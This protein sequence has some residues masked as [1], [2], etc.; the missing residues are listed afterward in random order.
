MVFDAV[1]QNE[2]SLTR[3]M[4]VEYK[5]LNHFC[6]IITLPAGHPHAHI[7]TCTWLN[8]Q[9]LVILPTVRER[10][11]EMYSICPS[12]YPLY[13]NHSN[14]NDVTFATIFAG[15][16]YA[17][18]HCLHAIVCVCQIFLYNFPAKSEL[19]LFRCWGGVM[20]QPSQCIPVDI[21]F[22]FPDRSRSSTD[23]LAT[24][25]AGARVPNIN[26]PGIRITITSNKFGT[27]CDQL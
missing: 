4:Q 27:I 24:V 7:I 18:N 16:E 12:I 15:N 26:N 22:D 6:S 21:V 14:S 10:Q 3:C 23:C 8:T 9:L 20:F 19:Q 11:R 5:K 2:L 25:C 17:W 13:S 1:W